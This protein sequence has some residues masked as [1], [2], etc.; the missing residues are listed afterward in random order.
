MKTAFRA[1]LLVA[2]ALV[3]TTAFAQA[4]D[5]TREPADAGSASG[6]E[7][8]A[9]SER[10]DNVI[11]VTARKRDERVTDVPLS[12]SA[13]SG[14]SLAKQGITSPADLEKIVPGFT[15]QLS[16]YGTPVFSIRGIG[17]FDNQVAVSPAVT[18]YTDQIPIPYA[19]MSEGVSLDLER[20][21]VLK[22]PQGTLFGQNS[23]GGAVNYVAAK[24]TDIFAAGAEATYG[25][26]NELNVGGFVSG[27]ITDTLGVRVAARYERRDGWQKSI[28]RDETSGKRD[29]LVG[30]ILTEWEPSDSLKVQL[31][32]NGWRNKSDLQ[33]TQPRG[34]LPVNPAAPTTP[35]TIATANALTVYPY[36]TED[37]NRLTDWDSGFSRER[38][39]K[40]Y[41]IAG[42]VEV[43]L[44]DDVRLISLT[45]YS[46]LNSFNPIDLDGTDVPSNQIQQFGDISSFT[47]EV[48][49]EGAIGDGI[50]WVVGG[51]YQDDKGVDYQTVRL[52]GS[53]SE[54]IGI[55]F[56]GLNLLNSQKIRDIAAF[57][58]VDFDITNELGVQLSGRYT[59]EKRSFEGCMSDTGGPI[60][61]RIPLNM[62]GLNIAPG[63]CITI[64]ED[65]TSG[66][67]TDDL[68]EDN[69]SWRASLDYK[70]TPDVLLYAN[71]TKGYKAG[72]F[73]TL[74]A[75]TFV[76]YKPVTQESVL[77]YEAG[78]KASL[79]GS[80]ELSGAVFYYDYKDKQIQGFVLVPPFG[81]LPNL[82]NIP[83][84]RLTGAEFNATVYPF[85]CLRVNGGVTYIDSKVK[86][87]TLVPSPFGNVAD[88]NGEAF[89]ATP[90]WQFQADAEYQFSVGS[91][92]YAFLGGG[93]SYRSGTVAAFGSETGPAGTQDFFDIK[94]YGLLDLR[95]GVEFD[96]G[97]RV[98]VFG[99]NVTN[100][101][102][103]NNVTH[104]YDTYARVTGLPVTYGITVS[105]RY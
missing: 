68:N 29:F 18:V 80:A 74:P 69:F 83:K 60:G 72:S 51:N 32:I 16:Q 6:S 23:T 49:L 84:S 73:G 95:A 105:A 15:F 59:D 55:H 12:I 45:S 96:S 4:S 57:A 90:K 13:V 76:Q 17:F 56:D 52:Q 103:W 44:G 22:G 63:E 36:V 70:V 47:Q 78:F 53:N 86:G 43:G 65:G 77:A 104:I 87:S 50:N 81:N 1:S 54:L 3:S 102:Y 94:G 35:V 41:Q 33:M 14:D 42:R 92:A 21:E 46:D 40:F 64:L 20:V 19:R 61:F 101:Q 2:T 100:T 75:V 30:R 10:S 99:R 88:A 31:N 85:D 97:Y 91:S 89:P 26:F 25:R 8:A 82:I 11:I 93:F 27:P 9:A 62:V 39:D 38:D 5:E 37:N 79:V 67:H 58:S 24:P 71:L 34:Y 48:R 98:Q 66:L 28:T 7:V